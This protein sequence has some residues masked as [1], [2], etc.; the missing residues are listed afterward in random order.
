MS[1]TKNF[2]EYCKMP[3]Y[4]FYNEEDRIIAWS[5]KTEIIKR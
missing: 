3:Y 5:S 2:E 4:I 1:S